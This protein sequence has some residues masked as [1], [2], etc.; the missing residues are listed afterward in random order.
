MLTVAD[1]RA[2]P[3]D[4]RASPPLILL[5]ENDAAT[6]MHAA[7]EMLDEGYEVVETENAVEAMGILK[8]RNDFD[9]VVADI[10]VDHA[11]GGL[12]LV[13]YVAHRFEGM[14]ILVTSPPTEGAPSR[15]VQ[16]YCKALCRRCARCGDAAPAG[17]AGAAILDESDLSLMTDEKP[18]VPISGRRYSGYNRGRLSCTD[19]PLSL[20]WPRP[21]YPRETL[22]QSRHW[23]DCRPR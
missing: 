1:R 20:G 11:P 10:D 15:S 18:S 3:G 14:E 22:G 4:V 13:R 6:R 21:G 12:A 17:K 23:R 8:G 7:N 16:I 5:V 9:A 19:R 2:R